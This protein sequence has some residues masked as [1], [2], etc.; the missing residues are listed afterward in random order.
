[1]LETV[2][3]AVLDGAK[4]SRRSAAICRRQVDGRAHDFFGGGRQTVRWR[5]RVGLFRLSAACDGQDPAPSA[6]S[7]W[8]TSIFRCCFLQGSR[9]GLADLKLLKPLCSKLADRAELFVVKGG[10]HSF[11]VLKSARRSDEEVLDDVV[12]KPRSGLEK[13]AD[14]SESGFQSRLAERK[15]RLA[16]M[17]NL[18]FELLKRVYPTNEKKRSRH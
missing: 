9:D 14:C 13:T 1:M 8:P 11:H 16:R 3:A 7:I 18:N 4:S 5:A 12:K 10:D 2:R 6:A 17:S 15:V